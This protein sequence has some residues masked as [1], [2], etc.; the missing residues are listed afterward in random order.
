MGPPEIFERGRPSLQAN[1]QPPSPKARS[2]RVEVHPQAEAVGMPPRA[3]DSV[4][5]RPSLLAYPVSI[6]EFSKVAA[7]LL[8]GFSLTAIVELVGRSASLH[9][10]LA[11]MSFALA[12]VLLILAIQAGLTA[13]MYQATPTMRLEWEPEA[14]VDNGIAEE[15]RQEQWADEVLARRYRQRV[16]YQY[17]LGI[18]AFLVGLVVVLVPHPWSWSVP[19]LVGIGASGIVVVLEVIGLIGWPVTFHNRI[20]PD[21][22]TVAAERAKRETAQPDPLEG[23]QIR[24]ILNESPSTQPGDSP[25]SPGP[26]DDDVAKRLAEIADDIREE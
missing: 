8:A 6:V 7:P 12:A 18:V 5:N 2:E 26:D 23:G 10:D 16:H 4:W 17:N 13:A 20:A 3:N 9:N 11:I 21:R 22:N 14:R 1:Q 25:G 19:R 15:V 24:Q